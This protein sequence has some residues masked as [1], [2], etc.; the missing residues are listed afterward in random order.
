MQFLNRKQIDD[1]RS[2]ID[3]S[4]WF[5]L[6]YPFSQRMYVISMQVWLKAKIVKIAIYSFYFKRFKALAAKG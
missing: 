4:M 2:E 6:A 3:A 1:L 5:E